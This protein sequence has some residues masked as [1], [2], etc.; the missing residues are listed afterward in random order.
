MDDRRRCARGSRCEDAL[1]VVT[2]SGAKSWEGQVTG[3]E[4]HAFCPTDV[5]YLRYALAGLPLDCAELTLM[6]APTLA[7][8]YRPPDEPDQPRVKLHAPLPLRAAPEAVRA[9]IDH[10]IT[11]A[12]EAT[13][14]EA[15]MS[16]ATYLAEVGMRI[17]A[18]V[19]LACKL[20]DGHLDHFLGLPL[21]WDQVRSAGEDPRDGWDDDA[22]ARMR[23]DPQGHWWIQRDGTD[24]ALAIFDLHRQVEHLA[25][26][27]RTD[28]AI[29]CPHCERPALRREHRENRA[30]CR[31]CWTPMSDDDY[32]LYVKTLAAGFEVLV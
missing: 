2:E 3:N 4:D 31:S 13:A 24:R 11:S 5:R 30:V 15:E 7:I 6:L 19:Q 21:Q 17:G 27:T 10:E 28:Q 8:T 16:R 26:R 32:D 29:P 12:A 20:I 25:G 23:Q 14:A 22:K 9:L 18:R 1:D